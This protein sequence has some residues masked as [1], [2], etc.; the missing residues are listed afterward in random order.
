MR[1]FARAIGILEN[2]VAQRAFPGA[3]FAVTHTSDRAY[4]SVGH[5]TYE[6]ESPKATPEAI[7]DLASLT[8][9][10]ATTSAAMILYERGKLRLDAP[11][12]DLIPD[13]AAHDPR[14]RSITVQMLLS[15]SSGLP[16]HE[17]L[18]EKAQTREQALSAALRSTLQAEPG[19][20]VEYSD[21][22]FIVLGEVLTDL[23][24]E[25][26]D[27]FCARE[28]FAPLE[29]SKTAFNPPEARR[30]LIPPT[31]RDDHFR[32]RTIQGEVN[33]ENASLLGGVAGHAGLFAP[34][35]DVARFAECILRGGAP[36]LKPE[37]VLLFTKRQYLPKGSSWALGWDTPSA[38]SQS[39]KL[40]SEDS[41][42]HLG[43]TGTS[44]WIDR[45]RR[46]SITLLTNRTWPEGGSQQ[47]KELRPAFHD[48][49]VEA[50]ETS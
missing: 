39:G 50:L 17:K 1:R 46:L 25:P 9:A 35:G 10:I 38:P 31:I 15:H 22:G 30:A 8:K 16:A 20:H 40:L 48:A 19:R 37:T 24:E 5:F 27:V 41:F 4:G 36:I 23:A 33:D 43:Y 21:I 49:I 47:I 18:Y 29:M 13:F 12:A 3:S 42:G 6:S 2:G 14:K 26:L 45:Q 11:I 7:F 32:H 28:I 34:A 44:L